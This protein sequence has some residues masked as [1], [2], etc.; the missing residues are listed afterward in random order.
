MNNKL[1]FSPPSWYT[2]KTVSNKEM[3]VEKSINKLIILEKLKNIILK[4]IVPHEIVVEVKGGKKLNH[5]RKFYPGYVFIYMHLY[6]NHHRLLQRPWRLIKKIDGVIN[7]IGNSSPIALKDIE[8][9]RILNKIKNSEGKKVPKIKYMIG[10]IVKINDGPFLNLTGK[11]DEIDP[12][13][14][15]LK[16]SVS[17]FE[18]FTPVELEYWQVE[19]V[20]I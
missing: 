10:D 6:D 9:D 5:A 1:Y 4:V 20:K 19:K 2:I 18:R 14:G 11:V 3:K 13:R 17:I 15:K 16:I 8:V 7:F 12:M